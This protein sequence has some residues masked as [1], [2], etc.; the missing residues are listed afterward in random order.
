MPHVIPGKILMCGFLEKRKNWVIF[1][2]DVSVEGKEEGI[3]LL[4]SARQ[5]KV[6]S[7]HCPVYPTYISQGSCLMLE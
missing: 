6:C 2:S 1:S 7:P 4:E 3:D 5:S